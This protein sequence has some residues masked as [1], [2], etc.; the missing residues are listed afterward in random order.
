MQEFYQFLLLIARNNWRTKNG[1]VVITLLLIIASFELLNITKITSE[2]EKK[3]LITG[4]L[5]F[6]FYIYWTLKSGRFS[7]PSGKI[8]ILLSIKTDEESQKYYVAIKQTMES[9]LVD[10][11]LTSKIKIGE[12][13]TDVIKNKKDANRFVIQH[14]VDLLVWGDVL[15]GKKEGILYSKF[16]LR[17]TF[18]HNRVP[19]K[20]FALLMS[21][22]SLSLIKR[23][24]DILDEDSYNDIIILAQDV[25][26]PSLFIITLALIV[27]NQYSKAY[28]IMTNL[29]ELLIRRKDEQCADIRAVLLGRVNALLI[30][31][32]IC[33][34]DEAV[35]FNRYKMA[36]IFYEKVLDMDPNNLP[37]CTHL[38][39]LYYLLGDIDNSKKYTAHAE[40]IQKG[41]LFTLA[42]EAFYALI[43]LKYDTALSKYKKLE[44]VPS[45][46]FNVLETIAFLD[47]EYIKTK[48]K[49]LLFAIG[50]FN[51]LFVDRKE[52]RKNLQSFIKRVKKKQ[53]FNNMIHYA[54][55]IISK[56]IEA[57]SQ[58]SA[59]KEKKS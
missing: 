31:I 30:E 51:I 44:I 58:K 12:L 32:L 48:N 46:P 29:R 38:A 27:G 39:K 35:D 6:C 34:G 33:Q 20:L 19:L 2:F 59:Y 11:S 43:E 49:G 15:S 17:Y 54:R 42:N 23:K 45:V 3:I 36:V 13:G 57:K 25:L 16:K 1:F 50:F 4:I 52:G 21:D 9:K 28:E 37:V 41:N 40:V 56:D 24:D 7:L 5:V 14:I 10:L 26:E 18:K 55:H 22:I 8:K 53:E 47:D